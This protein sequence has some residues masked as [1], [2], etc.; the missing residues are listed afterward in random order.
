MPSLP[1]V[2]LVLNPQLSLDGSGMEGGD[3]KRVSVGH[4]EIHGRVRR[5]LIPALTALR[6]SQTHTAATCQHMTGMA[7][8]AAAW[9]PDSWLPGWDTCCTDFERL[10][11]F[12]VCACERVCMCEWVYA[13]TSQELVC[14]ACPWSPSPGDWCH[15]CDGTWLMRNSLLAAHVGSISQPLC[16]RCLGPCGE[17]GGVSLCL[18]HQLIRCWVGSPNRCYPHQLWAWGCFWHEIR[19]HR[20]PHSVSPSL[21]AHGDPPSGF[22]DLA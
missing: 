9:K 20:P 19:F 2:W 4:R 10:F 18:S 7:G 17:C 3:L 15:V 22:Q 14:L 1:P 8:R 13:C 12:L 16:C 21:P 11:S 5:G 6:E